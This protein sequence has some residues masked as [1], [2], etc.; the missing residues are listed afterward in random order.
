MSKFSSKPGGRPARK[1]QTARDAGPLAQMP[2]TRK[3]LAALSPLRL[4]RAFFVHQLRFRRD[5]ASLKVELAA[6]VAPPAEGGATAPG[7]R[8]AQVAKAAQA[9][10]TGEPPARQMLRALGE[11][12]DA[13]PGSRSVLKH[14]AA[15]E[16]NLKVQRQPF[17]PGL[18]LSSLQMML[19]QLHGLITPPP[20]PEVALLLAQLLDAVEQKSE[21]PSTQP[22]VQPISSFFVDHKVEVRELTSPSVI[23]EFLQTQRS[24]GEELELEPMRQE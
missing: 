23:D 20:S 2:E 24:G 9:A 10:H 13:R 14:L 7:P 4:L 17:I 8:A 11:L 19:R 18:S 12:L 21:A 6:P 22:G 1:L 5:G 15:L 3:L 16:H